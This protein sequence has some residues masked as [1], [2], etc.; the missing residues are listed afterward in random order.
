MVHE[1]DSVEAVAYALFERVCYVEKKDIGAIR[2]APMGWERPGRSWIFSTYAECL[3][4]VR[5]DQPGAGRANLE[6][7]AEYAGHRVVPRAAIMASD[8]V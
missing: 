7:H 5:S 4:A 2:D 6:A 3:R 1:P 8:P